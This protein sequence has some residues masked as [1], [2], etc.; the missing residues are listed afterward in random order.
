MNSTH[1][2]RI[3]ANE[4]AEK[5]VIARMEGYNYREIGEQ[6]GLSRQ[7]AHKMVRKEMLMRR[8]ELNETI[9][10]FIFLENERLDMLSR[11]LWEKIEQGDITSIN[12]MLKIMTRRSKLL[13]LDYSSRTANK[14]YSA[15]SHDDYVDKLR[16]E[17]ET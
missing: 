17:L 2:R 12:T 3:V 10:E 4:R 5:A 14:T 1:A 7:A 16:I 15:W 9:D 8:I 13:G 6:L 11:P